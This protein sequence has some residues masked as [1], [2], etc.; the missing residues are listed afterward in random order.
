LINNQEYIP[1]H[2]GWQPSLPRDGSISKEKMVLP[3]A[4]QVVP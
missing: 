4:T 1:A 3:L 2:L